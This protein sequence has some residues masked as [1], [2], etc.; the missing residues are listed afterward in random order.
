MPPY[1]IAWRDAAKADIRALDRPTAMRIF[2]GLLRFA[3]SGSGDLTALQGDLAGS[4]R[5]RL[6]DYRVLFSLDSDVL[7]VSGVRHRSRAY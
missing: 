4:F 1:R 6:G 3:R 5:L 7:Y 2:D